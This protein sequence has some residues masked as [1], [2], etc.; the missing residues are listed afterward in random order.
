MSDTEPD[1]LG[2]IHPDFA[3]AAYPETAI[4]DPVGSILQAL[5]GQDRLMIRKGPWTALLRVEN[6]QE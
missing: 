2:Q 1:P 4:I 3:A 6:G 5:N